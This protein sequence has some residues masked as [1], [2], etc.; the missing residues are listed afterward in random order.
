MLSAL[1]AACERG[2][3]VLIVGDMLMSKAWFGGL[4][5]FRELQAGKQ[6]AGRYMSK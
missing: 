1:L 3:R 6:D 4:A 5:G 2:V